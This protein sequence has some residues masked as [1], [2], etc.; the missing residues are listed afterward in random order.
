M[1]VP[2]ESLINNVLEEL[3]RLE[4]AKITVKVYKYSAY[5]PIRNYCARNGTT[6]Y[7]PAT[8]N[9]F[10]CLQK[11]RLENSEISEKHF[12]MLRRAVLVLHDFYQN[13]TIQGGCRYYSSY[14]I[15]E[16]FGLCLK[17]FLEAQHLSK[18]TIRQLR[19]NI[20]LFLHHIEH[21]GHHDFSAISPDDVKD[22]ILVAAEKNNGGMPNVLYA[23][24]AFLDYLR[25]NSIVS[26]D[27]QPVLNRPA[28]RK[29]RVL[30]CFTHEEVEAILAQI[31]T[32]TKPG[33]RDYAILFLASHTGLR[34]IDIANLRL[35]D[36]D[37]MKD[38]IHIVQRKTGRPLA[39]PL[40]PDTGNA[41]AQYI[42]EARPESTSE[43]IFLRAR[44][45]YRKVADDGTMYNILKKYLKSA[46]IVRKPGDGKSFHGLRRSM[47][48]WMLES[49]V[50]LTTIS[51]VLG[52]KEQDST[53]QY[54]S[55]DHERLS[56]CALDFQE[57]PVGR[58]I[59]E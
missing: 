32:S 4:L 16:Y 17:Q 59:F 46:G 38:S 35:S 30:P 43:Y 49:G 56:V 44:A 34:S 2:L 55:M 5:S 11:K 3:K 24:R 10:I 15:S 39:L 51:Q 14:E 23:L 25:S 8:L 53:K 12:R 27:F 21:A 20:L 48:T 13:G 47:G 26:K 31:D 58:G 52:H 6:C 18:G 37:W 28:R 9:A 36:I 1:Q 41:I 33:K 54:L 57:I 22:Y 42:L 50:P 45:P 40:E 19:S 29:K 7:E